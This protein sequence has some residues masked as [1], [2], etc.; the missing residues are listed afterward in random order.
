MSC[1]PES[2]EAQIV[3]SEQ[4]L[5]WLR[6]Q[7]TNVLAQRTRLEE[8]LHELEL[9]QEELLTQRLGLQHLLERLREQFNNVLTQ[10]TRLEERLHEL[11][12]KEEELLARQL[13]LEQLLE[14]LLSP[15]KEE[16]SQ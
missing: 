7:H 5:Q 3:D 15:N 8:R 11:Q 10:R 6:E 12:L 1:E 4:N 2:R 9:K 14:E 13:E 16:N